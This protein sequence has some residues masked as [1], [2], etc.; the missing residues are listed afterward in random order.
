MP[1]ARVRVLVVWEPVLLT[2]VAPPTS[3]ALNRVLDARAAQ[4]WDAGRPLSRALGGTDDEIVWDRVAVYPAG[5]RW[6]E[7]P[8]TGDFEASPV[9][10]VIDEVRRPISADRGSPPRSRAS[11][12]SP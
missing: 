1:Q 6:D 9:V 11:D 5:S 10:D 4:F 12:P 3:H 8:P 2:D 7:S